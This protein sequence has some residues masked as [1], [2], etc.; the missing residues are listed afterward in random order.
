MHPGFFFFFQAV[1]KTVLF[2]Q[3]P[4]QHFAFLIGPEKQNSGVQNSGHC[5]DVKI[6]CTRQHVKSGD[7]VT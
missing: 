1:L 7:I 2:A 5:G 4:R 3:M 6:G